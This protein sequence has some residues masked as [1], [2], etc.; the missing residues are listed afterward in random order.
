MARDIL[1][2]E[3]V[4]GLYRGVCPTSQ[5]CA[6]LAGVQLPVYDWT[7]NFLIRKQLLQGEALFSR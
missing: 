3:G 2:K 4:A 6:L 7:K 5:R 1:S